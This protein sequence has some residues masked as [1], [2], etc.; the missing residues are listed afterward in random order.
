VLPTAI[1]LGSHVSLQFGYSI[2][3]W[4][5][6]IPHAG[7]Q[8]NKTTISKSKT[9]NNVWRANI[10]STDVDSTQHESS[11]GE[12][13]EAQRRRVTELATLNGLVQT[14]LELST[15]GWER[16]LVD[17]NVRQRS[18]SE[19]GGG[20]SHLVLLGGHL[21]LNGSATAVL[22]RSSANV[23]IQPGVVGCFSRR[24]DAGYN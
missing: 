14:G 12:S 22:G 10:P 11:Q 2:D 20:A 3:G 6:Y 4:I 16:R 23:L 13:A 21:R 1:S 15:K 19:A 7:K 18:V 5:G 8:L 17:V 9:D 24:H